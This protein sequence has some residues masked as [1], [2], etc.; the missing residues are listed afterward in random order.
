MI[1]F[2]LSFVNF[3]INCNYIDCD[4]NDN[5][6]IISIMIIYIIT[7]MSV[8]NNIIN[9]IIIIHIIFVIIYYFKLNLDRK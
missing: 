7:T 2:D 3:D 8:L 9:I 4:S 1:T 5:S 6:I